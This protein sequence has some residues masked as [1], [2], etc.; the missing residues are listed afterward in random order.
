MAQSKY[1]EE[2]RRFLTGESTSMARF[3]NV[4]KRLPSSPRCKLCATPF[5]GFGAVMRHFGF[6]RFPGNPPS[7]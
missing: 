1:D 2:L 3:R 7:A 5:D 6:A 4:M